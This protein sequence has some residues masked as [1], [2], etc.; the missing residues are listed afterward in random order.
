VAILLNRF[1]LGGFVK[2]ASLTRR[3]LSAVRHVTSRRLMLRTV[4]VIALSLAIAIGGGA[5]SVWYALKLP[6]GLGAVAIGPW[7]TFPDLGTPQAD[8]YS[9]AR[10]AREGVLSLGLAEGLTF[11]AQRDSAGEA[12]QRNC[13]YTIQ[14]VFPPARLWTLYAAE[15]SGAILR[16]GHR[17]LPALHSMAVLRH[18]DN[19]V[20]VAVGRHPAPGN[21]VTVSGDGPMSL[22]LTLYDSPAASSAGIADVALPQ[23]TRAE[24][25]D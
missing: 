25:D 13:T 18:A 22:V 1:C 5:A 20:S 9:K 21:W 11:V 2:L 15:T 7:T 6:E 24:C 16:N 10:I 4:F 8:P 3:R 14:G 17:R 12:L 19:S 23:I